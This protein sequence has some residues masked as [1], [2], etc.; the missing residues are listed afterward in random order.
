MEHLIS[1]KLGKDHDRAVYCH[2]A[3]LTYMGRKS[4]KM[5]DSMN[6]KVELRFP[7]NISTS[8][9]QMIPITAVMDFI[10]GSKIT[11][12][13]DSIHE[14]KSCLLLEKKAIINLF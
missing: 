10:L 7:G 4:W 11:A 14:F 1:S 2:L 12:D 6:H 3:Y 13:C 8:H 9:M 5:L